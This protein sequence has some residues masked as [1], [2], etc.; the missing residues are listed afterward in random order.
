MSTKFKFLLI[1]II[2][3]LS[4]LIYLSTTNTVVKYLRIMKPITFLIQGTTKS[5]LDGIILLHY[6]PRR[7]IF[8]IFPISKYSKY[9]YNERQTSLK[10]INKKT[11]DIKSFI[12]ETY[13]INS[14]FIIKIDSSTTTNLYNAIKISYNDAYKKL[15]SGSIDEQYLTISKLTKQ[16]HSLKTFFNYYRLISILKNNSDLSTIDCIALLL[17]SKNFQPKNIIL[18]YPPY[19]EKQF[20]D[21]EYINTF[22]K[23]INKT[24]RNKTITVEMLNASNITGLAYKMTEK[25]RNKYIDVQLWENNPTITPVSF[26]V[27]RIGNWRNAQVVNLR[28]KK[29]PDITVSQIDLARFIDVSII[30]G[31]DQK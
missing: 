10:N 16:L 1:S 13:N 19:Q 21:M 9:L 25:I 20:T 31:E 18:V 23:N 8:A 4:L 22:I 12:D 6:N 2:I 28:L 27:D 3:I 15:F 5:N 26:V 24:K 17:E 30:L 7:Q 14:D 29:Q 11:E